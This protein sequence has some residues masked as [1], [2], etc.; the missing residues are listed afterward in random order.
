MAGLSLNGQL[1]VVGASMPSYGSGAN[2]PNTIT[3]QAYGAGSVTG[4]G[5]RT[6]GLGTSGIALGATVLLVWLWWTLPR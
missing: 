5:P 2:S 6:A 4:S 1:G 3:S